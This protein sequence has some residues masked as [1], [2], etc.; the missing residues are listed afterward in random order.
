[1]THRFLDPTASSQC[2]TSLSS[3]ISLSPQTLAGLQHLLRLLEQ[4]AKDGRPVPWVLL[5]MVGG[6]I[7]KPSG[8]RPQLPDCLIGHPSPQLGHPYTAPTST[9]NAP[10]PPK[11]PSPP[12]SP[13]PRLTGGTARPRSSRASHQT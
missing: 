5:E 9:Q 7:T 8:A 1:M 4:A 10:P 11:P 3:T 12:P 6:A 2:H 13:L